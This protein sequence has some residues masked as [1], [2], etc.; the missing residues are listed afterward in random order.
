MHDTL[1]ANATWKQIIFSM[2][3]NHGWQSW[4]LGI[5]PVN[6]FSNKWQNVF[7]KI[8]TAYAENHPQ[9]ESPSTSHSIPLLV[10][11]S[12]HKQVALKGGF[13]PMR[14]KTAWVKE[15]KLRAWGLWWITNFRKLL[16]AYSPRIKNIELE[17]YS[18]VHFK[19][20]AW[21]MCQRL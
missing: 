18:H 11:S 5:L 15:N 4:K 7:P 19:L 16:Q 21:V 12:N 13:P 2:E 8:L 9:L 1:K 14:G 10:G 17:I 6:F 3:K 20:G